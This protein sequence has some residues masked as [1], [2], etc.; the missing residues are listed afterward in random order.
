MGY[1]I[2]NVRV[3]DITQGVDVVDDVFIDHQQITVAPNNPCA[4]KVIDGKDKILVPGLVDLHVHF[5]EPGFT[6]KED[7]A[8]GIQAALAGGV[9][10]ALVMP[11]TNPPL[12]QPKHI[13]YQRMR[14]KHSGFDL[15]VAAC[16]SKQLLGQEPSDIERLK[17][18]R[19]KAVTDDGRPIQ[20]AHLMEQIF[21]LCR[22]HNMV[23]MQHAEDLT[24]SKQASVNQGKA[25]QRLSIMGQPSCAESSMIERDIHLASR[26]GCRYH[27]LHMSC[28]ESLQLVR[29]AKR[30]SNLVTCEVSP[31]HLLLSEDDIRGFDANKK[32]NPPLRSKQDVYA[33][34]EGLCDGSI[35]ATASDHAPH[36]R[37]EKKR[38]FTQVPFGVVGLESAILILL[39]LVQKHGVPLKRA[40]Y[41]M[42]TGPASVL[43]DQERIGTMLAP[44]ALKN[45]VLIDIHHR[46]IFSERNLFGRSRNS[47][48]IGMEL[49]GKVL[50]TFVNGVF[51]DYNNIAKN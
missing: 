7:I 47:P 42:T 10:S 48:F 8:S 27:V 6:H 46:Q 18:A 16:A 20:D 13:F 25:S 36:S 12:D 11:N 23:F 3:I 39:T 24:M 26:I 4:H 40:L 5:R 51:F 43:E 34:I 14:A 17:K 15:M 38:A 1:L 30:E 50:A 44:Q 28:K 35:D 41:T 29:R 19:V 32:M 33:L 2:Q 21:R 9:T 45:A 31:H 49:Y 37:Q 22:R